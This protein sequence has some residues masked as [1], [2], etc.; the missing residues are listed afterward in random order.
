M[1]AQ[2]TCATVLRCPLCR[3]ALILPESIGAAADVESVICNGCNR[4][5][6]RY[7]GILDLRTT[8]VPSC[9]TEARAV[10]E[11]ELV[12]QMLAVFHTASLAEL[13]DLYMQAH[14]LPAPLLEG[15][16]EYMQQAQTRE[17]WSLKYMEFCT[18]RYL[19][20]RLHG[21]SALEAGCG[22][23]GML[24]HLAERFD[25][26]TGVD[27]DL[28]ALIIAAKRCADHG[29][30]DR[31]TLIAAMLE[32]PVFADSAFDLIKCTDV[33]EHVAD[34]Q[35]ACVCMAAALKA[36]GALFMLTPN[37]WSLWSPE[38]HVR[39]WGVQFLPARLAD[40]YVEWRIGI[41]YR[42]V[43][44]LLSYRTFMRMLAGCGPVG[45]VFVPLEDKYLNP[46]SRRGA[47]LKQV[48][49]RAPLSWLSRCARPMQPTL[50]ALCIKREMASQKIEAA[51]A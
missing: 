21:R 19:G 26:V 38:P 39:L 51:G 29:I 10:E 27:T 46:A 23:G 8:V 50:E 42:H 35:R 40:A 17:S 2:L 3:Q 44:R 1:T 31:V 25:Q 4:E 47:R 15:D 22:S 11:A 9:W 45:V 37:K 6:L 13:I 7:C 24:P 34:P 14:R 18:T 32:Q 28:P 20:A 36:G 43:A 16:R 41:P 12:N 49:G 33:I 30:A 5:Y 48:F